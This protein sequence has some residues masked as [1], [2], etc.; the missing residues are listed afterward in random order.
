MIMRWLLLLK[1]R[2][3]Q[4]WILVFLFCFASLLLIQN[5][6][7]KRIQRSFATEYATDSFMYLSQTKKVDSLTEMDKANN[8]RAEFSYQLF[9]LVKEEIWNLSYSDDFREMNRLISIISMLQLREY[10]S[11]DKLNA[12]IDESIKPIWIGVMDGIPYESV[13]FTAKVRGEGALPTNLYLLM[14]KYHHYLYEYNLKMLFNDELSNISLLYRLLDTILPIAIVVLSVFLA[15]NTINAPLKD[16]KIKLL[17][18]SGV[19]RKRIFFST[20]GSNLAQI[21]VILVIP[22]ILLYGFVFLSGNTVSLDYPMVILSDP[23]TEFEGISNFYDV[24]KE[25][26]RLSELYPN[27]L[28]R[29]PPINGYFAYGGDIHPRTEIVPFYQFFILTFVLAILFIA[30]LSALS[31]LMSTIFKNYIIS[32]LMSSS[33]FMIGY[34]STINLTKMDRFNISP[35]TMFNPVRTLEGVY[36]TTFLSSVTILF[37]STT[38]LLLAGSIIFKHKNI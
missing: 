10:Y 27:S 19:N 7:D 5:I 23:L 9:D 8:P 18:S 22:I 34:V 29:I 17:I 24:A 32:L 31:I 12:A 14:A 4:T 25:T 36:N 30:F 33:T 35:F 16:G 20:W 11:G 1:I 2:K 28:G 13:D 15:Y 6:E 37:F 21:I 3:K 38:V 26:G